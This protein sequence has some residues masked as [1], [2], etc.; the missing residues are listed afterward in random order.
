MSE[1]YDNPFDW[2]R[3][4]FRHV[5][6]L[7]EEATSRAEQEGHGKLACKGRG[8]AFC[9]YDVSG[10]S[11][12]E[13]AAAV[14]YASRLPAEEQ[15]I[16]ERQGE[17]YVEA[18]ERDGTLLPIM[19]EGEPEG[20]DKMQAGIGGATRT[21]LKHNTPCMFLHPETKACMIYPVR[22]F[23]CRGHHSLLPP[24]ESC[25]NRDENGSPFSFMVDLLQVK[26]WFY[27]SMRRT[28]LPALPFGEIHAIIHKHFNPDNPDFEPLPWL[29]IGGDE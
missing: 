2:L 1:V 18:H 27:Q 29:T 19:V 8:C 26:V 14:D 25:D 22:P 28:G 17:A 13:A 16:I 23:A 11:A 12:L 20:A 21:S 5:D 3:S 15:A 7:V 6:S 4:M 24:E 10:M 9:C